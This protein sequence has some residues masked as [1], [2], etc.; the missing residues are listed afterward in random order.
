MHFLWNMVKSG[1][2]NILTPQLLKL[3]NIFS[4]E[5]SALTLGTFPELLSR[6]LHTLAYARPPQAYASSYFSVSPQTSKPKLVKAQ[7]WP[8]FSNNRS[9]VSCPSRLFM[10]TMRLLLHDNAS[11][12]HLN[13]RGNIL[14]KQTR[15]TSLMKNYSQ[16]SRS[17]WS[18]A[19]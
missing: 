18:M 16:I 19:S 13:P 9:P 2:I 8:R 11:G 4:P 12:P 15:R 10:R 5:Q 3:E 17:T 1:L 14:R 7:R 6:F